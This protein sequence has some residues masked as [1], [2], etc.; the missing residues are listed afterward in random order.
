MVQRISTKS[1]S[2]GSPRPA[3]PPRGLLAGSLGP[4]QDAVRKPVQTLRQ[5]GTADGARGLDRP[6][7]TH[8]RADVSLHL[9]ASAAP[10]PRPR[11]PTGREAPDSLRASATSPAGTAPGRSCL[12]AKT[13]KGT[14]LSSSSSDLKRQPAPA[15]VAVSLGATPLDELADRRG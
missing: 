3:D 10:S 11:A 7:Q 8:Q 4:L 6:L 13:S 9:A 12:L 2:G 15:G 5:A 14:S 1:D